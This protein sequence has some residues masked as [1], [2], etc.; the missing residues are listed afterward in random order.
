MC[1]DQSGIESRE[2]EAY[3]CVG[4]VPVCVFEA[5]FGQDASEHEYG[6]ERVQES[7]SS[8]RMM[9]D[10]IECIYIVDARRMKS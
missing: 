8:T 3:G 4:V 5:E 1:I 2:T 9:L 6:A 10:V 7:K